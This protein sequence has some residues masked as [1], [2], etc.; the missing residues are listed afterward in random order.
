MRRGLSTTWASN[1]GTLDERCAF[2]SKTGICDRRKALQL[3][4]PE[5]EKDGPFP[6][7]S[8]E[9]YCAV[10]QN[11][12]STSMEALHTTFRRRTKGTEENDLLE[13]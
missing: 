2:V 5:G 3:I 6:I 8:F 4:A 9:V 13:R 7:W 1:A 11:C 10:A 12:R